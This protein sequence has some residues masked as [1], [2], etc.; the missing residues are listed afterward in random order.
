VAHPDAATWRKVGVREGARV[1]LYGAPR[2]WDV[3]ALPAGAT[4]VRR[5]RGSPADV[6]VEANARQ[7]DRGLGGRRTANAGGGK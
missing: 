3:A 2:H 6:V 1:A 5:R 7:V 4:A